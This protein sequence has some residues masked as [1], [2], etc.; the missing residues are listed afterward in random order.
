MARDIIVEQQVLPVLYTPSRPL[1][2][3]ISMMVEDI[4]PRNQDVVQ[5]GM[6][7]PVNRESIFRRV[8]VRIEDLMLIGRWRRKFE[9]G[10]KEMEIIDDAPVT[11]HGRR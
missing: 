7:F 1:Y 6:I 11:E 5:E 4:L 3:N 9:T 8:G 10:I 2:R